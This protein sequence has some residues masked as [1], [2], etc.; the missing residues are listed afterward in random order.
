MQSYNRTTGNGQ[1]TSCQSRVLLKRQAPEEA[2]KAASL[3]RGGIPVRSWP[4]PTEGLEV[5]QALGED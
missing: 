5:G 4:A 1:P 2:A 3:C